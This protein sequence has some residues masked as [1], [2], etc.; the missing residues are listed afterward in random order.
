MILAAMEAA[1]PV[2]PLAAI[3]ASGGTEELTRNSRLG[4][5]W[6][7]TTLYPAPTIANSNTASGLQGCLCDGCR[8]SR[9]TGKERDAESGLDYFGARYFSG[10][11]GRFTSPDIPLLD[12][13]PEDPQSWN[14]YSYVRNNPLVNVDPTGNDC[15]YTNSF[16]SDGTVSVETGNCS[17]KGGTFVDGTINLKSITYDKRK[18][19]LGYSYTNDAAETGGAGTIGLPN[20]PTRQE[21]GLAALRQAG[22]TAGQV[23]DPRF[24]GGWY[25]SAAVAGYLMV[26]AGTIQP[27]LGGAAELSFPK[28]SLIERV[29]LL[30][31]WRQIPGRV[32]QWYE[33]LPHYH[34]RFPGPGGSINRH[35]PW[36]APGLDKTGNPLSWWKRF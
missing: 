4:F 18:S 7:T 31:D 30:G 1:T 34:R 32:Y 13:H 2:F 29:N 35:R 26:N 8:R 5:R 3:P 20:A 27:Y 6:S 23:T 21:E 22:E 24:I 9:S 28:G 19:E 12:Q 25:A 17:K 33:R 36:E 10:A 15:I 14:L 11:Q 16:S